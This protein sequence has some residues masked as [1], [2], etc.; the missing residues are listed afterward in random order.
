[1]PA[2]YFP[3]GEP[4][5]E[6]ER[7]AISY[8]RGHLP[9]CYKI[10]ANLEIK[11]GVE[12]FEIDLII[13]APHCVYVVDIKNWHGRIEIYDRHWYPENHQPYLSP[14]KKLRKHAK[15]LSTTICDTN[16]A[17]QQKLSRVHIQAA[18]LMTS[19]DVLVIDNGDKDGDHVTYLDKRCLDYFQSTACVPPQRLTIIKP[20]VKF[21]EQAIRG[22]SQPKTSP[23][24]YLHWQVEEKLGGNDRYTEYRATHKTMGTAECTVRLRVYKVDPL[25]ES[26]E[27]EAQQKLIRTAFVAVS[28]IPRHPNILPVRDYFISQTDDCIVLVIDDLPGQVLS[29]HVKKHNLNLE[30]KFSIM[31]DVLLGLEHVHKHGAIHRNITPDNILISSDGQ[32]CLTGFDYARVPNSTSTIADD[33]AEDLA[34]YAV[35]QAVECQNDPTHAS[36]QS[37]LFSAGLVFYT[38]LTGVPAFEDANQMGEENARFPV[39]PSER[40][41]ELSPAW[42]VWLQ[43]LC[44][45]APQDRFPNAGVALGELSCLMSNPIPM[46]EFS[47]EGL[48]ITNLPPDTIIDRRY[49]IIKRLGRPGSFGVAYHVFEALGEVERVLKLVTKDRRSVYERLQQEYKTLQKVPKHP[50]IV[51]VIWAGQLKDETPFIVFEY[52]EGQDVQHLIETRAISLEK[53]VEIVSQTAVGLSHLHKYKVCHQDIKPS[54]LLVTDTGVRIIDFNVAVSDGDEMT[55]SAG[56]LRYLPPDCKLTSNLTL[57]EKV[58]RDLYALG[59]VFYECVT[60]CYPFDEFQPPRGKLPRDPRDVEGCEDLDEEVVKLLMR[61]IAPQRSQR[62]SSA[63][64]F[65][66]GIGGMNR[67]GA[68]GAEVRGRGVSLFEVSVGNGVNGEKPIVLDPT[69]LYEVPAGY[70]AIATEVDWM[71]SFG[72]SGSPWWVKGKRLCDWAVEWLQVWNRMDEVAEIKS[73][74]RLRLQ[75]LFGSLPLPQEWSDKQIL[76]LVTKLDS[77]PQENPIAYLLVDV[78]GYEEVWLGEPSMTHL[79]TWLTVRVPQEC[80]PLEKVWQQKFQEC[81]LA[82]YYLTEDK[83]QLLRCWLGIA[84]PE[85]AE[86]GKYPLAIPDFLTQEFDRY[87]EQQLYLTQGEVLKHLPPHQAGMERITNIAVKVAKQRPNWSERVKET[88][89]AVYLSYQQKQELQDLQSPPQPELLPLNATPN[90]ALTWVTQSYL[91]YRRWELIHQSLESR[92]SDKP[93][94]ACASQR[95]ADSFVEWMLEHY[96]QMKVDSVEHS[97]L[98]Y[99]VASLVRNLCESSPVLWVVVDGLGWLDHKEL[100]SILTQ[101]RQLA[102]EKDIEPRFSILPTKTEYA[103]GSLYSQ[104]LPNSSAWEKDSIKKAFAKMGLGEHYTDSRIDRLRKDLRKRKHQLYCWDTT[105]FDELHHNSTDWQ[106]LYNIK[107]PH[108]LELIAREIV[109][110]V[111]EYPNPEELRVA[112]ASD[113][114]QILGTSEK[115]TC[116]P[117]LEPQG[118]IAKGK[119]TDPR[120][121]VLESDRYGLPYDISIVRSSASISSFS[122]NPDKKILGSHGG[123]FPEE[124]VIGFSV[125]K[126]TIQRSPV[127]ITCHGEGETGKPGTINITIDNPNSVPLTDLYLYIKE[128]PTFDTKKPIEKTIPANQRVTFQLTIPKTPELSLTHESDRLSLSG[129][130]TFK[131]AG[132][133]ISSANL[134]PDSQIAIAQMFISQGFDINE[135]L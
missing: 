106:H 10:F 2:E 74:P 103:K 31:R 113:H 32:A 132:H 52:V 17:L 25:L 76:A 50:Y 26:F 42:D 18:V 11:Q 105:Q 6:S 46:E 88:G 129:E 19:D 66:A 97:Y 122:Y 37:D 109:S 104:L 9:N 86:L 5:N 80:R 7:M 23:R 118:R 65:L 36:I 44:A 123:L 33:I 51:E 120:F 87:W 70:T 58:D 107:R 55:V 94:E 54:N 133:E 49:R 27:R 29:Q 99:S 96:P 102:V 69:G 110:F 98:N 125:L 38:L 121:V 116:P 72:V 78:A 68:E 62:F 34:E 60:G 134:T 24:L 47:L 83:F 43:K 56:T 108:T 8:L 119:T 117:E 128:L 13:I 3:F 101:N 22:K 53:A 81:N 95:I 21:V 35:Y 84:K 135:F 77:Y 79:A 12:I 16:R 126:K 40:N 71:R 82:T 130:L 4:E 100:L 48:D 63:E 131:F 28:K 124:V 93:G 127:I 91:P 115:I 59:I 75:S 92:T 30:Q 41:S 111:E 20:Y 67:R 1:M 61:A 39:K 64:E 45:F 57:E 85:I 114:G 89:V 14:L 15:V 73:N 112:I 90:Q